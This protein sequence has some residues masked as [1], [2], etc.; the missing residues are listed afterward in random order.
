[1][2]APGSAL[3]LNFGDGAVAFLVGESDVIAS[4]EEAHAV[5][6][7]ILDVWR[8]DGED[9]SHSWEDRFVVQEGYTPRMVEA[10]EGLLQKTGEGVD[11]FARI[12]LYAPDKRSHAGAARAL[13]IADERLQEPFFGRLGNT[14]VAFAPMQLAAALESARPGDRLLVAGYGD[15]AEALSF[16]VS[17]AIEKLG[18]R[19][20]VDAQLARR[21]S[22]GSYDSYLKARGLGTTEWQGGTDPGLSATIH[23]RERDDDLSLRGQKCRKCSA[24]QFPAQRVCETCFARDEFDAIRLSDKRAN[25][26]TYTLDF[27]FPNPNPPTVV[28]IVEVEGARIHLQIVDCEPEQVALGMPVEFVFRRIHQVGGRPNYYWKG[29]PIGSWKGRPIAEKEATQ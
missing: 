29:R 17:D 23:F 1:M 2:G 28:S 10:V 27:F 3:E 24:V 8:S 26:V 19:D 11:D 7:E 9:F 15:G 18:E 21:R 5:S 13:R 14:G 16:A 20:G 12:A 25:V 22:V 4:L 6:D